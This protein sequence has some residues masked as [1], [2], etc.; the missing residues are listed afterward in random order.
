[1]SERKP[2][3]LTQRIRRLVRDPLDAVGRWLYGLGIHP[4]TVTIAGLLVVAIASV[5]I[6]QGEYQI[7][8]LILLAGLPLDAVDGA[9]ARAMQRTGR[10][11]AV[12]DS[13]LDRYADGFI[14]IALSYHLAVQDRFEWMLLALA[15]LLGSLLV[16]YIR[17]R[18]DGVN[19]KAE[20]GIFTRLE[21]TAVILLMLFIP[22]LF[23]VGLIV[24]GIGTNLTALQRLWYVYR[25]LNQRGE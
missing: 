17:A 24:L 10:F 13:T 9:V 18:G 11:G 20:I 19:V 5:V 16:S 3:T 25:T 8:A 23:E 7:G 6:A 21:R 12:L 22:P 4:D 15:A 2:L 14:F 1:M